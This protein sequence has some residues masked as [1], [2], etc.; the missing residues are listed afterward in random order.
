MGGSPAPID[1]YLAQIRKI[2][3]QLTKLGP[4]TGG[5]TPLSALTDAVFLDLRRALKQDTVNLP[6]QVKPVVEQIAHEAA[7]SVSSDAT[8]ELEQRFQEQI[9]AP[10]RVR[11]EG[12]YPFGGASDMTLADFG[13]MFG[14]GG[15]YDKFFTEHLA[16]LVDTLQH[17]WVWRESSVQPA[18][19][20]L[21]RFELADRIRDVLRSGLQDSE[22]GF[23]MRLWDPTPKRRVS[24]STSAVR[25]A[26]SN[27]KARTGADAWPGPQS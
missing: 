13:E 17:P 14:Y 5:A 12:R 21:A 15:V 25:N 26:T 19:G 24:T 9:V 20:I 27:P 23:T 18:P 22:L 16:N 6:D 11:V 4:Q 3:D 2:R 7:V 1:A 8:R 10:C